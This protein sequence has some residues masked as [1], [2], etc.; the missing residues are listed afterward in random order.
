MKKYFFLLAALAMGVLETYAQSIAINNDGSKP[1]PNAI[2]DVKST[3]KGV[4]LPRMTT[5][6]RHK[7][8]NTKGLMVYDTDENLYWYNDGASWQSFYTAD[9]FHKNGEAWLLKGNTKTKIGVDFIGTRDNLPLDFRVNNQP[10]GRIDPVSTNTYWGYQAGAADSTGENTNENS[11][12]E[13]S[14]AVGYRALYS[15][16]FGGN[17][18]VGS[19]ALGANTLGKENAALG[20]GALGANTL[21][22]DNAAVGFGAMGENTT[23]S[24]NTASGYLA[25]FSNTL[26]NT[27][28]AIGDF[29]MPHNST[30]SNNTSLG[31]NTLISNSTGNDLTIVGARADVTF[32]GLSDATAI[33]ADA[34]VDASNKVRIGSGS[35]TIIEGQVPFTTP[36]D[37]RFKFNIHENVKGLD[38]ILKLRPVTYQFDVKKQED[39]TR[40]KIK[41]EQLGT[42]FTSAGN[43]EATQMIRTGFIAQEVEQAAKKSGYDFDG[44]KAP[45]TEKQYY[46]LSYSSFVVPLVKAVQ[47]QQKIINRQQEKLDM[48]QAN[49]KEQNV[50]IENLEHQ[51]AEIN[52][53]LKVRH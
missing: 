43:D 10:A 35:V 53:T 11:N 47:E 2:V 20:F 7:I 52:N 42:Y 18:A 33:G 1:N 25:L 5:A 21:G 50:R 8:P 9:L 24:F 16:M 28:T 26:G 15:N 36:S 46:S 22:F 45:Q 44:V 38:F 40:G 4:L 37:G 12:G 49:L 30:G 32:D 41:P 3:T 51:I 23:G 19:L 17:T 48:Q 31:E 39:F 27:N 14:T 29:A 34:T 6:E 13:G